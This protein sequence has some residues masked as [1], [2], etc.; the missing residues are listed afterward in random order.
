MAITHIVLFQFK[1]DVSDEV[2]KDA[3]SR[4]LSLRDNCLHPLSQKPYIR[5][6][7]GGVDNS[8]EGLQ[9]G[10]THAF[11][12]EFENVE[13]RDYYV[14]HDPAH[15]AFV[16]SLDGVMKKVQVIDFSNGVFK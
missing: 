6:S 7:A 16:Q 5:S 4:M 10:I 9:N 1:A 2:V 13:D 11:V 14:Q 8:I 12:V 3:C 15:R